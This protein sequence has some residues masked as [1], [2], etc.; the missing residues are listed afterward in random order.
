MEES[1]NRNRAV[2]FRDGATSRTVTQVIY[3][4]R[5]RLSL[6][7]NAI[8]QVVEWRRIAQYCAEHN[9]PKSDRGCQSSTPDLA[10]F[11]GRIG[12]AGTDYDHPAPVRA[13]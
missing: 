10:A 7:L 6:K 9:L 8:N 13:W 4:P 11:A 3:Q 1:E 2:L 5:G 12:L